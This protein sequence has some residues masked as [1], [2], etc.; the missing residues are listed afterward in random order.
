MARRDDEDLD[1]DDSLRR[2]VGRI[3]VDWLISLVSLALIVGPY[4]TT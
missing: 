2:S 3:L 4:V 1:S